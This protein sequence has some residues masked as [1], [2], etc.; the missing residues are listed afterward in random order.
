MTL[1][2]EIGLAGSYM[3]IQK[4]RFEDRLLF[5]VECPEELGRA[6]ILPLTIQPLLENAIRYG[7][8]EMM[9]TCE[10]SIRTYREGELLIVE[11]SNE[12]SVF[13]DGL[14]EKLQDGTKNAHGFGIGLVNIHQR[15]QMFF[16][17]SYGLSF[18]NL[19]EKAIAVITIPYRTEEED[20]A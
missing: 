20:Y 6:L 1:D 2:Y 13:E 17:E 12:G 18:K 14:L 19:N 10:I 8:E 3:T 15:I 5:H 7:M 4:I 11:V 16:G 9:D